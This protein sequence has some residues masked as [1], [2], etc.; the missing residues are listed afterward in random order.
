M[1]VRVKAV[2]VRTKQKMVERDDWD[3]IASDYDKA[4]R[5]S[6]RPG[7]NFRK[8]KVGDVI[9]EEKSVR[10]NREE[11][12][13]LRLAYDEEVKRLNRE[14][15]AAIVAIEDRAVKL[16]A[17]EADISEEKA[18]LLWDFVYER[19]HA[20]GE[21]FNMLDDYIELAEKLSH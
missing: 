6:C 19:G 17:Y 11:V 7:D 10:W 9:D 3:K 4:C 5:M 13:R 2:G 15:N 12:E 18:K 14:K 20:Y 8:V 21:M 1:A 16:I